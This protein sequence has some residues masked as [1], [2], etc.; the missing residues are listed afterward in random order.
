MGKVN[1]QRFV[2]FGPHAEAFRAGCRKFKVDGHNAD[3][4]SLELEEDVVLIV[5]AF[6]AVNGDGLEFPRAEPV[7]DVA[8]VLHTTR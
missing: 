1:G 4:V 2:C 6:G 3:L 5:G 7:A 8:V